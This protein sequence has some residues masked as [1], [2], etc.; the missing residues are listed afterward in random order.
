[1]PCSIK[2]VFRHI[3]EKRIAILQNRSRTS[4]SK[5]EKFTSK[6]IESFTNNEKEFLLNDYNHFQLI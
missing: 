4:K 5:Q 1:M 3:T 6:V 2:W